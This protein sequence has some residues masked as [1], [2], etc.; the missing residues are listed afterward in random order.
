MLR[1]LLTLKVHVNCD[2]KF[3]ASALFAAGFCL[4]MAYEF[5]IKNLL[6]ITYPNY[7]KL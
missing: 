3:A 6:I 2:G 5:T 7:H 1:S 4:V